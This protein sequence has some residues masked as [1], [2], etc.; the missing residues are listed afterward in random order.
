MYL[1]VHHKKGIDWNEV[2]DLIREKVLQTPDDL[3]VLCK[4]CHKLKHGPAPKKKKASK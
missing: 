3:T 4:K 1:E 2:V